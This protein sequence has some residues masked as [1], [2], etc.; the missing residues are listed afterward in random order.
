MNRKKF[1]CFVASILISVIFFSLAGADRLPSADPAGFR[2]NLHF[3]YIHSEQIVP[4]TVPEILPPLLMGALQTNFGDLLISETEGPA[5]FNQGKADIAA[6]TGGRMAAVWEDDRLG[7][8]GIFLQLFDS[9]GS[10][11]GN[12]ISLILGDNYNLANPIITADTSGN[13]Y[14]V[15]RE[16]A[17]GFLQAA[18]FDSLGG[19]LTSVFFVSDTILGGYA[20]E[21]DA[22]CLP[23]GRLVVVWENY[24]FGTDIAFRIF[25]A[26]GTPATD[27][28]TAN[29]DGSL[30]KHWSPAVATADNGDIAVVWE[31]YR[32]ALADIYFRLFD[33]NGTA[34][35]P[36]ISIS[37]VSASDSARYLPEIAFSS[38]DGFLAGWVDLRNGQNIYLQS[39]DA[40]G[41]PSGANVLLTNQSSQFSNW[42]L[43]LSTSNTDLFLASWTMYGTENIIKLQLFQTGVVKDGDPLDVS[44]TSL[45]RFNSAVTG[46]DAGHVG[47]IWTD[48]ISGL[49]DIH[50][51]FLDETGAV[52]NSD[53][54]I[55][56]DS[57][58][59]P[60]IE[61]A[62]THF[63]KF[64][65][66]VVFTDKRRD[67]GDI[68]LQRVYVG[69]TL[70]DGNR[71]VNTDAPGA[72]Q[73]QPAV[74]SGA[75]KACVSWTDEREN[76]ISGRN[77]FC[78]FTL[79]DVYLTDEMVVNDDYAGAAVHYESSCAISSDST[80][81]VV[82]T[83]TRSG[84]PKIYGQLF[85]A[86]NI[87]L[88]DNFLIGP[89]APAEI[90]E[91]SKVSADGDGYF[92]VAYLNRLASGGPTVEVK[93]ID[94]AGV[95]AEALTFSSPDANYQIGG[96]DAQSVNGLFYMVWQ[97]FGPTGQELFYVVLDTIGANGLASVEVTDNMDAKPDVADLDLNEE[98]YAVMTWS[99]YRTGQKLPFRQ[100]FDPVYAPIESN[101]PVFA[102]GGPF[103]QRP[104][105]A[106]FRGRGVFV[107]SDARADGLNVYAS[108]VLFSPTDTDDENG[109]LPST[110][111]LDQ[112]YPNP[113]NPSTAIQFSMAQAGRVKLEV[114]N[115]LGQS[116]KTLLDRNYPTGRH[117]VTWDGTSNEDRLVASG[118]YFYRLTSNDFSITRKMVLMK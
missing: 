45:Q 21:F 94:A 93:R 108:Q 90:G 39:I 11:I 75:E 46:N 9:D 85:T 14:V 15:W 33:D 97:G 42:E 12:N 111:S 37:D 49:A 80:T 95:V 31:D 115:L 59:S 60:S 99:D 76:G 32:L 50:G 26:D 81:L 87:K 67:A 29:S 103:M 91:M 84:N 55:N 82:W 4:A 78:R 51:A 69:E 23:D 114:F 24:T 73:S 110:Y 77:I 62:V 65:W 92:S 63:N 53:F 38:A 1:P 41:D 66:I 43:D 48:L 13:F 89:S 74:A 19:E 27:Q 56:D 30:N 68:M 100:I 71:L 25:A 109:V 40:L 98:G 17:N 72:Y 35:D 116:V 118:I 5:N 61:P 20:G 96:F 54:V 70:Y 36:E 47:V 117:T 106:A 104:A 10:P 107:W 3:E 88:G 16:D 7:P 112:N 79:R 6:L 2:N 86:D 113:F 28:L 34:Y 18:S 101:V 105:T 8:T 64:E 58:G 102:G 57:T 52:L 83:D 22:A 44:G